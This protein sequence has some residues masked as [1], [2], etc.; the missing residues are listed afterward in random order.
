M[1]E[2]QKARGWFGLVMA[3]T[4]DEEAGVFSG[5]KNGPRDP[6]LNSQHFRIAIIP[7]KSNIWASQTV[8][9]VKNP[10]AKGGGRESGRSPG[11]GNGNPLQYS[12]LENPMDRGAWWATVQGVAKSRTRLGNEHFH[13]SIYDL[14]KT[15]N[16]FVLQLTK[17]K[18]QVN[19]VLYHS[20]SS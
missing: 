8:L 6:N 13:T 4:C 11:E 7:S 18:Y 19:H 16:L 5:H 15:V 17:K 1:C 9:A 2:A 14:N 3:L 20:R 12:C 10:P